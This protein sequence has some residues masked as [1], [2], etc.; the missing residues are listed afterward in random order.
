MELQSNNRE[1]RL[2]SA[3]DTVLTIVNAL[4][5]KEGFS[6]RELVKAVLSKIEGVGSEKIT[7]EESG[8]IKD[9]KTDKEAFRARFKE[10]MKRLKQFLRT[11][12]ITQSELARKMEV[13][14]VNIYRWLCDVSMPNLENIARLKSILAP[15]GFEFTFDRQ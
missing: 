8:E 10:D 6:A 2:A 9:R 1:E 11:K 5:A 7:E 3:T 15:L 14:Q 12:K 4:A 13:E